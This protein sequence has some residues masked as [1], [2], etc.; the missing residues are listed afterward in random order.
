MRKSFRVLTVAIVLIASVFIWVW[1]YII[2]QL[3]GSAHYTEQDKREYEFY[4]PVLLKMMPRITPQYDFDFVNITGPA[5]HVYAI[6]FYDTHD[7]SKVDDYLSIKGYQKQQ[8]C[9]IKAVCWK[10]IDAD[11]TITVSTLNNPK[12]VLVSVIINF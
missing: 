2:M 8:F 7:T 9:H 1:P 11:E 12:V 3:S 6:R 5:A 10:G 4:T